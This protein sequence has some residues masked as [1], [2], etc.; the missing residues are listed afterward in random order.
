MGSILDGFA[1]LGAVASGT[2]AV[3]PVVA[4][5]W[6]DDVPWGDEPSWADGPAWGDGPTGLADDDDPWGF[7][8]ETKPE[9]GVEALLDGLYFQL[10]KP[11]LCLDLDAAREFF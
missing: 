8:E 9:L 4:P 7:A 2:D 3:L 11:E 1:R 6:D 10:K 5:T